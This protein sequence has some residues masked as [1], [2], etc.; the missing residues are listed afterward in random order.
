MIWLTGSVTPFC[1][2]WRVGGL[3]GGGGGCSPHPVNMLEEAL[4]CPLPFLISRIVIG[5]RFSAHPDKFL[6][7]PAYY[8]TNRRWTLGSRRSAT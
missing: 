6:F 5:F 4:V 2:D 3:T 8:L 7:S 1:L